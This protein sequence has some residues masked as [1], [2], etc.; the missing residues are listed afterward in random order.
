MTSAAR[1]AFVAASILALGACGQTRDGDGMQVTAQDPA[2]QAALLTASCS[3][4]HAPGGTA[5]VSLDGLSGESIAA[6][7]RRYRADTAGTS[8]MH[9]LAR[10]FSDEN[11]AL[12]AAR[13]GNEGRL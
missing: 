4:C 10:G 6:S 9:R 7:L 3:G 12:I 8:V 11:V 5:I 1:T 13:I 2:D